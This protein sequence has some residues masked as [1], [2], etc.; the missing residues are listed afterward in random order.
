M[1]VNKQRL[2]D[3][4]WSRMPKVSSELFTLTYGSMVQQLIKDFEV[5]PHPYSTS[6]SVYSNSYL[7]THHI[8]TRT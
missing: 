2:G 6:H 8:A 5:I 3:A 4:A 7:P 1:A